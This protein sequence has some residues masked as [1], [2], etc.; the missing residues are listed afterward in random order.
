MDLVDVDHTTS[1]EAEKRYNPDED[2]FYLSLPDLPPY[3]YKTTNP[4]EIYNFDIILPKSIYNELKMKVSKFNTSE[5]KST[6]EQFEQSFGFFFIFF[7]IFL[8]V[9]ATHSHNGVFKRLLVK[10]IMNIENLLLLH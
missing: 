3:N 1:I 2:S 5:F 10:R 4:Q 7:F 9:T 8:L 6:I